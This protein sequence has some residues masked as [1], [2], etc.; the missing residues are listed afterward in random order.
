[1]PLSRVQIIASPSPPALRVPALNTCFKRAGVTK[2]S[3]SGQAMGPILM[4][5]PKTYF[6]YIMASRRNGTLYVGITND[7]ERRTHE[8]KND[9]NDGFTKRYQVHRLVWYEIH[10]DVWQA[11]RREKQL[12]KWNRRWKLNLI[13]KHNPQWLDLVDKDG[14]VMSLPR[15]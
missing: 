5:S 13:E 7:I 2:G 11:I 3:K 6:V 8:H 14:F 9:R 1:M 15:E 4:R 10:T 12:K